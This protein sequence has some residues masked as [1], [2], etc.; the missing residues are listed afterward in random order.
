MGRFYKDY[1]LVDLGAS[2]KFLKNYMVT[3]S[4]NN[5][6][7]VDFYSPIIYGVTT[8]AD[9]SLSASNRNP[10]LNSYQTIIPRRNFYLSLRYEF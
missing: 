1:Q 10:I 8:G 3:F 4:I 6:F 2:F 5:L 7:D 9:G